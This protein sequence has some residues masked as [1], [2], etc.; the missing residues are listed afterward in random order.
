MLDAARS[1][2]RV[3]VGSQPANLT[4]GIVD[5]ILAVVMLPFGLWMLVIE[6]L[7]N[8]ATWLLGG[9]TQA[10]RSSARADPT[11]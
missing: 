4:W 1:E 3:R 9:V 2:V 5:V 11:G 8:G 10:R 7:V 6:A